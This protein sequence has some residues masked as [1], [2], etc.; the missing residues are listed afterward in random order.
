VGALFCETGG[1]LGEDEP[2][3]L[4]QEDLRQV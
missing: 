3:P 4:S 1:L 2:S